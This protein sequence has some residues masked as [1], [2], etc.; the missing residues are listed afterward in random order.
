MVAAVERGE[1]K[2]GEKTVVV[3]RYLGPKGGPGEFTE[4]RVDSDQHLNSRNAGNAQA[5]QSYHGCWARQRCS[6]S[7][8]RTF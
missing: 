4:F 2:K 8:R 6:L 3:M 7:H 1:I 5:Y